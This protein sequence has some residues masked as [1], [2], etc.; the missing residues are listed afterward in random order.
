MA[1]G[2][3]VLATN[4]GG[5]PEVVPDEFC[6]YERGN[7]DELLRKIN[8][9]LTNKKLALSLVKKGREKAKKYAFKEIKGKYIKVLKDLTKR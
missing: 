8:R 4:T 2:K 7:K 3:P 5:L 9:I 1:Q 6:L